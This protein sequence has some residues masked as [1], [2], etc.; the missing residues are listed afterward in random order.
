MLYTGVMVQRVTVLCLLLCLVPTIGAAKGSDRDHRFI[1]AREQGVLYW[2]K[3][4]FLAAQRALLEAV[5]MTSG[6]ADFKTLYFLVLVHEKLMQPEQTIRYCKE[7][8]KIESA[9]PSRLEMIQEIHDEL[10]GQYGKVNLITAMDAGVQDGTFQ[11][12]P[13]TPFINKKKKKYVAQLRERY[14]TE[15][16]SLPHSVFLPHG[17]YNI[18]GLHIDLNRET[19]GSELA[20]FLDPPPAVTEEPEAQSPS[21]SGNKELWWIVGGVTTTLALG[22]AT[23]FILSESD[24]T[25]TNDFRVSVRNSR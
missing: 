5:K 10:T 19:A 17:S 21:A 3:K 25:P 13:L 14:A 6:K 24:P 7:A 18:Q 15:A 11:L 1:Q 22:A 2:K 9:S 16:V 23:F 4:R 12:R 20:I 8:L